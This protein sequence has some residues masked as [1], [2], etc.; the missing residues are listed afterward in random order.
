MPTALVSELEVRALSIGAAASWALRVPGAALRVHSV[1]E[2]TLNL[3]VEGADILVALS[4]P[5]GAVHPYT[6]TLSS[7]RDFRAW[8]R[9]G[10]RG[11]F[12]GE[13]IRLRGVYRSLVV[14]LGRARRRGSRALP[15]VRRLGTAYRTCE[16][17]LGRI[18]ERL[19][20]DLRLGALLGEVRTTTAMGEELRRGALA[21]GAAADADCG[22]IR[23]RHD[24]FPDPLGAAVGALAGRGGGLTPAGDDFLC[25]FMA[26]SRC[27]EGKRAESTRRGPIFPALC[28][29]VEESIPSTGTISA[30][31]LRCA[32]R[33]YW[34]LPLVDLA[35]ALA[36][37]EEAGALAAL[38][39]LCGLGHSSGADIATGFLY[40][41]RLFAAANDE[42]AGGSVT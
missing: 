40:G 2:S 18:Q 42:S 8:L 39:E 19:G 36:E 7:A 1:F 22:A 6:V 14:D 10:D 24:V 17:E 12:D 31:L 20:C 25:G 26:A 37:N 3:E 33:D 5:P 34:S 28:E 35:A 11:R 16:S 30:S 4:G 9:A 29:A 41:L 38:A 13:S 27:T 15:A 23:R 21:L 32:M